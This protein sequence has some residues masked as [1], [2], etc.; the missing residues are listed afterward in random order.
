MK[1]GATENQ[2]P[3]RARKTDNLLEF[4]LLT[5]SGKRIRVFI[6]KEATEA[7][8]DMDPGEEADIAESMLAN[9]E[10]MRKPLAANLDR[11]VQW[12]AEQENRKLQRMG[13]ILKADILSQRLEVSFLAGTLDYNKLGD[14]NELAG[15]VVELAS[16]PSGS[17]F[18]PEVR[19]MVFVAVEWALCKKDESFFVN[20]GAAFARARKASK[21]RPQ[22]PPS[23]TRK[24]A[25][26]IEFMA[27][28][29]LT[30]DGR[31]PQFCMFTDKAI[32]D[33]LSIA[34]EGVEKSWLDVVRAARKRKGLLRSK[35]RIIRSAQCLLK[36]DPRDGLSI[37]LST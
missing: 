31:G 28:W 27:E 16:S 26:H 32:A 3:R 1:S 17:L 19:T 24:L 22:K 34:F 23:P 10:S 25:P 4:L 6:P 29:W 30:Q 33:F 9:I 35:R 11:F 2:A 36:P 7:R 14:Y 5:P 37:K 8:A 21:V 13:S 15:T 18:A 12:K 20:L